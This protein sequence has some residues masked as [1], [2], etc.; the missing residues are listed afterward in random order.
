[1][2]TRKVTPVPTLIDRLST[3]GCKKQILMRWVHSLLLVMCVLTHFALAQAPTEP[4]NAEPVPATP[5]NNE[6]TS[7]TPP[8][9]SPQER[10][11]QLLAL[12]RPEE[13]RWLET[14]NGK[15][16]ALYRPTATRETKGVLLLL[17]TATSPAGLPPALENVRLT[18]TEHGWAT[19]ALTLPPQPPQ[20]PPDRD[21]LDEANTEDTPT[22]AVVTEPPVETTPEEP[23]VEASPAENPEP[24]VTTP[25]RIEV[26]SQQLTA[27]FTWLAQENLKPAV[28]LVDNSGVVDSLAHLQANPS[29][30]IT[31]L[32][33]IN[34]Q[35]EEPLTTAQLEGVFTATSPPV[36]DVFFA[37]DQGQA[38]ATRKHHRAVAQRNQVKAYQQ[39]LL[40]PPLVTTQNNAQTF[41]VE[42]L[43]GFMERKTRP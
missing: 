38:A 32:V 17:H 9:L 35:A 34:L 26:I 29:A 33:L 21:A 28:L 24:P 13:A 15:V 2:I 22:E 36:L 41:W 6:P 40:P 25:S 20:T 16:L 27:A 7:E 14:P 18:L 39:L 11:Q 42:R 30:A 1:M 4:N 43:R 3:A 10:D 37:P 8:P 12:A 23:A 5:V 31:A 19:L